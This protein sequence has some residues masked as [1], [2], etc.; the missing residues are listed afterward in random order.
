M[1]AAEAVDLA[2]ECGVKS[3]Q[4]YFENIVKQFCRETKRIHA[5]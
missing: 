5:Q 4:K 2:A 3:N 1:E